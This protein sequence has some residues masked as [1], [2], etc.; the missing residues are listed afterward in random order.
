MQNKLQIAFKYNSI[1][2]FAYLIQNNKKA[3]K[4]SVFTAS[5]NYRINNMDRRASEM[6][7]DINSPELIDYAENGIGNY[8]R[9]NREGEAF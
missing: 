1:R 8:I 7:Q 9:M 5:S 6:Q 2:P 3:V 4:T